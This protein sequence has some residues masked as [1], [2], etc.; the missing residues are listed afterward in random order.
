MSNYAVPAED[1]NFKRGRF[2]PILIVALLFAV[3]AG[4]VVFFLMGTKQAEQMSAKQ[5]ADEKKAVALLP[6]AEAIPKY[7]Q[8]A[9]K[10]EATKLQEEAFTQLAWAKDEPGL[11]LII[12]GLS[13]ND[14]RVRGTAASALLEYAPGAAAQ[15]NPALLKAFKEADASDKPQLA[16]ALAAMHEPSSFD[17]V[18]KEYRE[19]HLSKVQRLDGNPAFDPE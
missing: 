6:I 10:D 19:G 3:I 8:W 11:A 9:T 4:V 18:M 16:W 13:S 12:K 14:H 5:I 7:R 17:E 1:G 2:K 15:A